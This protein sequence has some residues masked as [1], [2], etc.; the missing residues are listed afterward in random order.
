MNRRKRLATCWFV[1]IVSVTISFAVASQ[2]IM[3]TAREENTGFPE[4]ENSASLEEVV[5]TAQRREESLMDVPLAVTALSGEQLE[6]LGA[7]DLL[8][9]SQIS[10]NTSLEV[11]QGTN[12][13][14]AAYI[15]G[16]GQSEHIAGFEPGVGL[17]LDDV[18]YNRPQMAV[19]D[20]YDVERI[21]VLRGPQG[22]LYGRNTIG[23]AIKYVTRRLSEE[24]EVQLRGSLGNFAMRD[25]ILTAS[26]PLSDAF[27]IGGS[28][29]TF[30]RAGFGGNLHRGGQK[31]YNKDVNAARFSMEWTPDEDWFIRL[32][33]DWTEDKSDL[34][35]GH[36]LLPG[37]YSGAPVL[38]NVFDARAGNDT[39]VASAEAR[40]VSLSTEWTVTEAVVF[41][42]IFASREDETWKP[43]DLD[44]LPT[45][46][47]DPSTWDRND[48]KT[49]ELQAVFHRGRWSGVAGL[50]ALDASAA[51]RL[52]VKLFATGEL[53]GLPGLVNLLHSLVETRSW[54][55][56]TDL[57]YAFSDQ[58]SVSL[59]GRFT[60]D[61]RTAQIAR[62]VLLGGLSS[63]FGGTGVAVRTDS[64]F[65]GS[66]VFQQFT[67]RA[68]VQWLS[69]SG[70][71]IYLT[72]SEGWKG[73]GFDPR[74]LTTIAPDFDNDG[75]VSDAEI[76]AFMSFDP[77]EV[78]SWE[79]GWKS[80][81][82]NGR[83]TSRLAVFSSRY[84]NVQISGAVG[85]DENGDG[86]EEQ[87]VGI[88]TNAADADISGLEW[89]WQAIVAEN[90]GL[91]DAKLELSLALGLLH[92]KFNQFIDNR[93]NEVADQSS[94]A[95]SPRWNAAVGVGYRFPVN[96]FGRQGQF[97]LITAL[98]SRGDEA[99]DFMPNPLIDQKGYTLWNAS[100]VWT[101][102][103]GRWQVGLY[104]QNLTDKRYKVSGLNI[105]LG[106]EDNV[107]AYYGN[108][109]QYW[110]TVQ[111]RFLGHK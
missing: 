31:N 67:P 65:L 83:T 103:S 41:R 97:E 19:L 23:G 21:E 96:W 47:V 81:L 11:A 60:H 8:Y 3:A 13:S 64:D 89:E 14:L 29:A 94:F 90:L 30:N 108:P 48:Q 59:G 106:L 76:H 16:V 38:K 62:K 37:A 105:S 54:A 24:A 100:M 28:F 107:T 109:R 44:G 72:Y 63:F 104:G 49:A 15:R 45:V 79:L 61:K 1:R 34:R 77:E 53:I 40:G 43:V 99:Q 70:Q 73:G 84:F 82:F 51:T 39:P 66:E 10:P 5:V 55:A 78:K 27:R 4:G 20:V 56:Y 98:S 57:S 74:G 92:A 91:K 69:D 6:K 32:A 33:A 35:R 46:D 95:N 2:P 80:V 93:G 26:L 87:Y 86:I 68:A 52:E 71:N 17:Y 58:W 7:L 88:T 50:F 110:L 102:A 25:A 22:T 42:G 36:R 75:Q 9:L 101:D 12:N 111:Y 85:V 18:Y